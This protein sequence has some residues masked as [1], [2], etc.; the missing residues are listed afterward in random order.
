[1]S[2]QINNVSKIKKEKD[3]LAIYL[4]AE[5]I[6]N[7]GGLWVGNRKN[8]SYRAVLVVDGRK[9]KWRR[10]IEKERGRKWIKIEY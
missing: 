9:Y 3:D 2:R 6:S 4:L 1:L 8:M 7:K 5:T 10:V